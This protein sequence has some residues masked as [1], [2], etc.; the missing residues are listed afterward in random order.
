MMQEFARKPDWL[1]FG[2]HFV[3]GLI[4]GCVLGFM[5]IT[6]RR[7]GIWLHEDLI[8][9][10]LCGASL[11]FAGLGA[12]LG[13]RLW[14]GMNYRVIPPDVPSHSAITYYLSIV[15]VFS[16]I[17]LAGFALFQHFYG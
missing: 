8:L 9:P 17:G 14:L 13:D 5:T 1:S 15:T 11:I 6:R 2:L 4:V 7:H 12:K 10:Y 16:G 3:F